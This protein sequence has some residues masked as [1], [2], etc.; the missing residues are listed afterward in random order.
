MILWDDC[1]VHCLNREFFTGF[2]FGP[3]TKKQA[4]T[5]VKEALCR[6]LGYNGLRSI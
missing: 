4:K 5:G 1:S 6:L 2:E 3:Q